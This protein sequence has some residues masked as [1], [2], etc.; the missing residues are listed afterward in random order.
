MRM[1]KLN[2][3]VKKRFRLD[4]DLFLTPA[5]S[6]LIAFT[7]GKEVLLNA[8]ILKTEK[9][10]LLATAHEVAHMLIKS[11][12]H[13]KGFSKKWISVTQSLGSELGYSWTK[14]IIQMEIE[15]VERLFAN[16]QRFNE[17]TCSYEQNEGR[18]K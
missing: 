14:K 8:C 1:K 10:V 9:D 13:L 3:A 16:I 15:K 11:N 5:L 2:D 6:S 17:I 12:K 18:K 4:I 7:N